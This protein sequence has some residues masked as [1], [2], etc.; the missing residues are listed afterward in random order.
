MASKERKGAGLVFDLPAARGFERTGPK[1]AVGLMADV[2][3]GSHEKDA[4]I[5]RLKEALAP[6]EGGVPSKRLDP[7]RITVSEFANRLDDSFEDEAFNTLMRD[8]REAGGNVQPIKV[9][10][11]AKPGF[12]YEVVFGH[13]RHRACLALGLPVLAIIEPVSTQTLFLEMERENRERK[14]LS[15]YEQ[16]LMYQ[17]ALDLALY[18]SQRALAEAIDRDPGFVGRARQVVSLP[19]VVLDAF[20]SRNDVQFLHGK[21]LADA[22]AKAPQQV[23]AAAL[24]LAAQRLEGQAVGAN[25]V[26]KALVAAAEGR[27]L[28]HATPP[29]DAIELNG[30]A[31]ANIARKGKKVTLTFDS[32]VL[33]EERL[34]ALTAWVK[35]QWS[36]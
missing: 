11:T 6:F 22:W 35:S 15:A 13:R 8:I 29:T 28:H 20:A 17:K 33:T 36:V 2:I 14:N 23:E 3:G 31:V 32:D 4:E 19:A 7:T 34:V 18:P 27:G 24:A 12:D 21:P 26:V 10:P 16:G 1:T 9:R 30:R 5:D 25:A